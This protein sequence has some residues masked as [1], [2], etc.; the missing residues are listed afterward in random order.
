[1]QPAAWQG[2]GQMQPAT[3]KSKRWSG[4]RRGGSYYH[5]FDLFENMPL[6]PCPIPSTQI[7]NNRGIGFI[8][9]GS[10]IGVFELPKTEI[11]CSFAG[12]ITYFW[13]WELGDFGRTPPTNLFGLD[14]RSLVWRVTPVGRAQHVTVLDVTET[15]RRG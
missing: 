3:W 6:N 1:M 15:S 12:G 7:P 9:R 11:L 10:E 8:L 13:T 5:H 14:V 2:H 4:G